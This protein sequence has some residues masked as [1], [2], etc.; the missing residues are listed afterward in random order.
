MNARNDSDITNDPEAFGATD[1]IDDNIPV[2]N[3]VQGAYGAPALGEYDKIRS[4][5]WDVANG[6]ATVQG[7]I[8]QATTMAFDLGMQGASFLASPLETLIGWGLDI[9]IPLV[10]PIQDA[11]HFVTGDPGAMQDEI[12]VWERVKDAMQSLGAEVEET[13]NGLGEWTGASAQAARSKLDELGASIHAIGGNCD[14]VQQL[15]G[16]AQMVALILEETCKWILTQLIKKL[17]IKVLTAMAAAKVTLGASVVAALK[18][19]AVETALTTTKVYKKI[20]KAFKVMGKVGDVL[21]SIANS[22]V[23]GTIVGVLASAAA[24]GSKHL[25][26]NLSQSN[27]DVSVPNI[28]DD[29][30]FA[31]DPDGMLAGANDLR[32]H[33]TNA[34]SILNVANETYADDMSWGLTGAMG[35]YSSYQERASELIGLINESSTSLEIC[36]S[37][38]EDCN[39]NYVDVDSE[40]ESEFDDID[41]KMDL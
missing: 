26:S 18:W 35:F 10:Q 31:T 19:A 17:A 30:Y 24:S 8:T 14:S 16:C 11:I 22:N 32:T 34:D 9:L 12:G 23:W 36:A 38:V 40:C 3:P 29:G 4:S 33:S 41:S 6:D 2:L 21:L 13:S 20:E 1:L 15:L 37:K 27:N 28:S 7:E 39:Q 5:I 25:T